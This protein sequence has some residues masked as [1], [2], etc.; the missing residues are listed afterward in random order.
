MKN[1][2]WSSPFNGMY[3]LYWSKSRNLVAVVFFFSKLNIH[4]TLEAFP[5]GSSRVGFLWQ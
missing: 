4:I 3:G 2:T 1:W 5:K